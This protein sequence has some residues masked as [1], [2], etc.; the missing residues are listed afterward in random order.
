[1]ATTGRPWTYARPSTLGGRRDWFKRTGRVFEMFSSLGRTRG[2]QQRAG[3]KACG[4][5]RLRGGWAL[6]GRNRLSDAARWRVEFGDRQWLATGSSAEAKRPSGGRSDL[7]SSRQRPPG[8]ALRSV[9]RR[10][11]ISHKLLCESDLR[12]K[13]DTTL[14]DDARSRG[15]RRGSR[16]APVAQRVQE[17]GGQAKI[18]EPRQ[19]SP[20]HAGACRLT[21]WEK[22]LRLW[23]YRSGQ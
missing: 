8:W 23:E 7:E 1:M 15:A 20:S 9:V 11:N 17:M 5:R 19:P 10:D 3:A 4:R 14:H 12:C 16:R 6:R 2:R 21:A 18:G 22:C 13:R